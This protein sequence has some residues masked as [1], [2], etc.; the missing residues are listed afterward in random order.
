MFIFD[1]SSK[2]L[3]QGQAEK[4]DSDPKEGLKSKDS[5]EK[6]EGDKPANEK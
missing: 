1:F 5:Q 6:A 4:R 2:A 3:P